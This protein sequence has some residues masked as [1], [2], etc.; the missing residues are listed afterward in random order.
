[1]DDD[2]DPARME[3]ADGLVEDGEGVA[4]ADVGGGGGVDG[5]EAQLDPDG[6]DLV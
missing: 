4:A 6:L 1:M 5:L 2:A 3:G